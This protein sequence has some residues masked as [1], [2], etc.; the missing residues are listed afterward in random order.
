MIR[1]LL[2][3]DQP[4]IRQGLRMSLCL[5]PDCAVV[6]EA[7]DGL[8]ALQ[9]AP[10][11]RPDVVVM[12]IEMPGMD[13]VTAATRLRTAAPHSAVVFLSLH[14]DLQT[15]TRALTAGAAFVGKHEDCRA[16]PAAIR[17]AASGK[18]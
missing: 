5:E 8:A 10:T 14:D 17:R 12:D 13:G 2:V 9:L 16:L 1:I 15:R 6:G 7:D 11:L 4:R 18:K 3:D